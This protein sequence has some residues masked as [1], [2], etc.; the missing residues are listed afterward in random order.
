[1]AKIRVLPPS[2]AQTI[3]A[4]EVVERPASVL[5]ELMENAIDAGSREIVV[6]LKGGGLERI[7]VRDNGEGMEPD[8]LPLA[9]ER[10]ATSK[11]RTA[12]DLYAIQTLGF[13]GE[14]LPSIASVSRMT[15][16]TRVPSSMSGVKVVCEGGTLG[17]LV[18]VGCPIGT[19]VDV[20]DL[21]YNL[22]VKKR[23]LKSIQTELRHC[24]NHFVRLSLA[25]PSIAF[26]LSHDGKELYELPRTEDPLIRI[27][28]L[29]GRE[30]YDHLKPFVHE[31]GGVK[32]SGFGSLPLYTRGNGEG[33]FLYV[34]RRFVK[35]RLIYRAV[36]E[37]YRN[38]IPAPRF[39]VVLLFLELPASMVD[40]NVHPTKSEVKFR[41]QEAV[42]QTVRRALRLSLEEKRPLAGSDRVLRKEEPWSEP[43][44]K[45]PFPSSQP[46]SLPLSP[47]RS[48]DERT[49]T[50]MARERAY[51]EGEEEGRPGLRL[52]GQV[53]GTYLVFED[54]K[55]VLFLDQHACHERI[56]FERL[57]GQSEQGRVPVVRL[58]FPVT[59]ELSLREAITL[60]AHQEALL[61]LGFEIDDMGEK[62][63]ALRTVPAILDE[64]EAPRELVEILDELVLEERAPDTAKQVERILVR[65]ACHGAIRANH[66]LSEKEMIGLIREFASF[67]LSSTCPH[68]RPIVYGLPKSE[69]EKHFKRR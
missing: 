68:G 32:V 56:L 65:L 30:V 59:L 10:H 1:V 26:K 53:H 25:Y 44:E 69:L 50:P 14:A 37:A 7:R 20:Q 51:G 22:P 47:F 28:A 36:L 40:V 62:T 13:R 38:H 11:L 46:P 4:G 52:L 6:E 39:P 8:D 48:W 57:K 5:K 27:E 64:R 23:F 18:E 35:D 55:G 66:L 54:E 21:F 42:F 49:W 60:R 63:F 9:F 15:I 45:P 2:I 58:L 3:A 61:R 31:E 17:D 34:N 67:P 33:I 16:R 29:L 24:V 41:Q 43:S 19:D 12:E